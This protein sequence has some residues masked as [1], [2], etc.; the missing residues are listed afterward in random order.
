MPTL[1][2]ELARAKAAGD[3]QIAGFTGAVRSLD[4]ITV[5]EGDTFTFPTEYKVYE[6][7]INGGKA[8]YI[9]IDV[10]GTAK[11]F[12]PSIFTKRRTVCNED[13]SLTDQR[14]YTTGSAAE[15]FRTAGSV[16]EGME[17]LKGKKVKVTRMDIFRT[18]SFDRSAVVNCQI[19]V[20]DLVD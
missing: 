12:Y 2:V 1:E 20:I 16:A 8:Q 13:K 18:L 14:V 4:P 11:K 9:F 10:E 7:D 6:Q 15:L 3:K 17:K 5:E 19:P